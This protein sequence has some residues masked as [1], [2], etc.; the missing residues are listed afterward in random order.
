MRQAASGGPRLGEIRGL[1]EMREESFHRAALFNQ[2]EEPQPPA[3]TGALTQDTSAVFQAKSFWCAGDLEKHN[4][5]I[6]ERGP[7]S[8]LSVPCQPEVV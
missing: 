5:V 7:Q 4:C 2:R 8:P 3:T 6:A 1:T